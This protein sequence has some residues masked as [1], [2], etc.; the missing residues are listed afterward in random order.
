MTSV[1]REIV[2]AI[3]REPNNISLTSRVDKIDETVQWYI[4]YV[5][6]YTKIKTGKVIDV[7][8]S[9][10][11]YNSDR[12][13][14]LYGGIYKTYVDIRMGLELHQFIGTYAHKIASRIDDIPPLI[15]N[16]LNVGRLKGIANDR[17][18]EA[19]MDVF[20]YKYAYDVV[21]SFG[22]NI[23]RDGESGFHEGP[24]RSVLCGRILSKYH[25]AYIDL[26][27]DW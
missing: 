5:D 17:R 23:E 22:C 27:Y 19:D 24:L 7:R 2:K 1:Y 15:G 4:K 12:D 26:P 25:Q 14:D 11:N 9:L 6:E 16:P 13:R 20:C 21:A 18:Y 3:G 10:Q 8:V